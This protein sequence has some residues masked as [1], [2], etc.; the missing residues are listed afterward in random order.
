MMKH[1]FTWMLCTLLVTPLGAMGAERTE[2]D[3]IALLSSNA[4]RMEKAEACREL[5]RVGTPVAVPALAALLEDEAL[6]HMARYA[7]EPIPGP[8]VDAVLSKALLRV[9]GRQ[10]VGVIGSMGVRRMVEA[11]P[12]LVPLLQSEDPEIRDATA[13][14]LGRIGTPAA[15]DALEQVLGSGPAVSRPAVIEGLFR[16]AE[17]LE[18]D[19]QGDRAMA[20][21]DLLGSLKDAPHQVRT[22]ATR[23][24]ILTR[25]EA[26]IP[27]LLTAL[28]DKKFSQVGA[29]VRTAQ[30]LPGPVAT[31]ALADALGSLEPDTQILLARTLGRRRDAVASP[32]LMALAAQGTDSAVRVTAVEALT[33]IGEASAAPIFMQLQANADPALAQAARAGLAAMQ[34]PE[35]NA[36]LTTMLSDPDSGVQCTAIE[37]LGQR[38]ATSAVPQLLTLAQSG[39]DEVQCASLAVLGELA[40][41]DDLTGLVGSLVK[42]SSPAARKAGEG[43]LSALSNRL[44]QPASGR[45]EIQKALYGSEDT[46]KD[47]T[48]EL[49]ALVAKGT[50]SVQASNGQFGP[51]PTPGIRKQM[52]V[53]YTVDGIPFKETVPEGARLVIQARSA[54]TEVIDALCDG[55]PRASGEAKLAL[56]RLLRSAGGTR[57]LAALRQACTDPDTATREAAESILCGWPTPEVLPEL[58]QLAADTESTRTRI[59]ALRGCGR[60]I[61]MMPAAS[62][63]KLATLKKVLALCDRVDEQRLALSTLAELKSVQALTLATSYL[64]QID[65]QEE[66]GLAAV[67]LGETLAA[68]H[69]AE[70]AEAMQQVLT[71]IKNDGTR[72]RAQAVLDT[73]QETP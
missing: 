42:T 54:P 27:L 66:A 67:Q 15:A 35:I 62:G 72:Q 47:V 7:L 32:A 17:R 9:K 41:A 60:L 61:P 37:L 63:E 1:G 19:G 2:A 39:S 18:A 52:Q 73:P 16:C 71:T 50:F 21:Y 26:G 44:A 56:L 40:T 33:E 51:D 38:R 69:P 49:A 34:G 29:A 31:Q 11:T 10:Q 65:L 4:S 20:I 70:V 64:A 25:G 59:L 8:E 68:R 43:A 55:L 48:G 45:I 22:G 30:E 58:L 28:H 6:S 46:F 14:T 3:W 5:V 53:E 13:R 24:S 36:A 57:A 23:G 12:A